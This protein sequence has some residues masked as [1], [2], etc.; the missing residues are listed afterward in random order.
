MSTEYRS[1]AGKLDATQTGTTPEATPRQ[2][3]LLITREFD[4][5]VSHVWKTW[6]DPVSIRRWWRPKDYTC[7]SAS[8][9]LRVGGSYLFCMRSSKGMDIWSTGVYKEIIPSRRIVST[10]SFADEMGNV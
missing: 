1:K 9:D 10:D 2:G 7:P 3:E 8:I 5:P 6:T 4:A